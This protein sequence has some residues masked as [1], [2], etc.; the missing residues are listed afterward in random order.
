VVVAA[1]KPRIPVLCSPSTHHG[2]WLSREVARHKRQLR[3]LSD[4]DRA[5]VVNMGSGLVLLAVDFTLWGLAYWGVL[6]AAD[7]L[8]SRK[9]SP[10][11]AD[12]GQ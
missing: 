10:R 12:G 4:L 7:R 9:R 6:R 8:F 2:S 3:S 1:D 11:T 5:E